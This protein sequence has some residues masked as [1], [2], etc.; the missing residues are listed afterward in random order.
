MVLGAIV[1]GFVEYFLMDSGMERDRGREREIVKTLQ[2]QVSQLAVK[3]AEEKGKSEGERKR[4][5]RLE[6]KVDEI[7]E[8]I[9]FKSS[10]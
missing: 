1:D 8:Y 2:T 10:L 4:V 6:I 7:S 9:Y 5:G 3:V